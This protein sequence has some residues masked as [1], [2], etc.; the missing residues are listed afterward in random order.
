MKTIQ[1][2]KK[3]IAV[4]MLLLGCVLA[5]TLRAGDL[6][7]PAAPASTMKTLDEVEARIPIAGSTTPVGTIV[8]N[9]PGSYYLT[10]DRICSGYGIYIDS[11]NV[12][13]DLNGYSLIGPGILETDPSAFGIFIYPQINVEVRNGTVTNFK[14]DGV[15]QYYGE[16]GGAEGIRILNIRSIRNGSEGIRLDGKGNLIDG[17]TV[18]GNGDHG[19]VMVSSGSRASNNVV[20]L[21]YKHGIYL[22]NG[23]TNCLFI[24][25]IAFA[26]N[27]AG[28]SYVNMPV[29]TGSTY[30]DNHAP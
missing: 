8:I 17:C 9:E 25:N 19:I 4:F 5:W 30:V 10:G 12:T 13:L 27:Q 1:R 11:D 14:A 28:G 2:N 18:Q 21:N 6:N 24:H 15:C 16:G 26:N 23:T 22:S 3:A 7:P 20:S 29:I